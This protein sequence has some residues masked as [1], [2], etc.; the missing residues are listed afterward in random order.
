MLDRLAGS[1]SGAQLITRSLEN[2]VIC[3]RIIDLVSS[4]LKVL[5]A[6]V[7]TI[8]SIRKAIAHLS[9]GIDAKKS[10]TGTQSGVDV[11]RMFRN[12]GS[13]LVSDNV[14]RLGLPGCNVR[15][16]QLVWINALSAIDVVIGKV[17]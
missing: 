3:F 16:N 13:R 5:L 12:I 2:Q 4:T 8:E 17:C 11:K 9:S 15:V 1:G 14:L 10:N 7:D 6:T